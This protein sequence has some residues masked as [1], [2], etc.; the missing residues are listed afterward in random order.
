MEN[1]TF[2]NANGEVVSFEFDPTYPVELNLSS[3][4][5]ETGIKISVQSSNGNFISQLRKFIGAKPKR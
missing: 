5:V 1:L 2:K 3:L 4:E